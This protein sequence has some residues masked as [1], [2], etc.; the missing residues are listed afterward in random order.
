M[1]FPR[2]YDQND[3]WLQIGEQAAR[4]S[5]VEALLAKKTF[6]YSAETPTQN[7]FYDERAG[8]MDLSLYNNR[9]RVCNVEFKHSYSGRSGFDP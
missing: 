2:R 8:N 7:A 1:V 4:F 5:F 6:Q 3:K 9:E